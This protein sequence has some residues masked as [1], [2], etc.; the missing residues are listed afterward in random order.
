MPRTNARQPN[1]KSSCFDLFSSRIRIENERPG[2]KGY[3]SRAMISH[4]VRSLSNRV[5][6]F[7]P[8]LEFVGGD[9]PDGTG[10]NKFRS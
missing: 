3:R 2:F 1:G 4:S 5:R 8:L 10:I 7:L 9:V 6:F